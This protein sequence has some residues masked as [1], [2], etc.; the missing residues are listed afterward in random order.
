LKDL[1]PKLLASSQEAALRGTRYNVPLINSLVL[2]VGM[3]VSFS[4]A[5]KCPMLLHLFF[6]SYCLLW[7]HGV[8]KA[9][10]GLDF[11]ANCILLHLSA[12]LQQMQRGQYA[13]MRC[14]KRMFKKMFSFSFLP[15]E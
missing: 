10:E 11:C 4:R 6:A 12:L 13:H 3:Q 5:L 1:A 14:I 15:V 2:Y 9:S 7:V 8:T